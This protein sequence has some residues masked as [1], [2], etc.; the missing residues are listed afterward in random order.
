MVVVVMG[1]MS[2]DILD[3]SPMDGRV[4]DSGAAPLSEPDDDSSFEAA[5]QTSACG[6]DRLTRLWFL[7]LA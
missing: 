5:R 3:E 1:E 6:W 7:K 4:V 2:T